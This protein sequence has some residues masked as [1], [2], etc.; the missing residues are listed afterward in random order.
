MKEPS[1]KHLNLLK[2]LLKRS[3]FRT[4]GRTL[5]S[6]YKVKSLIW[7]LTSTNTLTCQVYLEQLK[8]SKHQPK[9]AGSETPL[10]LQ[11]NNFM[12]KVPDQGS[13][14]HWLCCCL[15]NQKTGWNINKAGVKI[16][17]VGIGTEGDS[18]ETRDMASDVPDKF[19]TDH[20]QLKTL[21]TKLVAKLCEG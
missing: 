5:G 20:D 7:L 10:R 8:K 6:L 19:Y 3:R 2:R 1:G 9:E 17:T 11:K 16:Y 21:V 13:P 4:Q 14:R 12:T 15:R 18:M